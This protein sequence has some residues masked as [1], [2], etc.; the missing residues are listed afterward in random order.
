MEWTSRSEEF[1]KRAGFTLMAVLAVQKRLK[2]HRTKTLLGML[3]LTFTRAMGDEDFCGAGVS[4]AFEVQPGRPHHNS[5][6]LAAGT[7][8][9]QSDWSAAGGVGIL[10]A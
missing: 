8:A 10:M 6:S 3:S 9:P 4:P 7:V 2:R 1:V 5:S